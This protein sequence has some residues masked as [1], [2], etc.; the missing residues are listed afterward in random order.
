MMTPVF[1]TA[2]YSQKQTVFVAADEA[3]YNGNV[4]DL[5]QI[6]P[7]CHKLSLL[8]ANTIKGWYFVPLMQKGTMS[9]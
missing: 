5:E 7:I 4:R 2:Y 6:G 8:I 3:G 9:I 1:N